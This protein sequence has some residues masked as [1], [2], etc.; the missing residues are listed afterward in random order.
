MSENKTI[1][2]FSMEVA[3][4]PEIPNFAGG[5]GVL[6]ADILKSAAD[7]GVPMVGVSLIYHQH[8]DP[9]NAFHPSKYCEK[10]PQTIFVQ[11]EGRDVK[12]GCW[13]YLIEGHGGHHVPVF[14]LDSYFPENKPWDRDLTKNLYDI[15]QYTRVCQEVILGIGGVRMLRELG[16]GDISVFHM[17]EGHASLLTLERLW[18]ERGNIDAVRKSCVFTTHTPIPAG[19]DRFPQS[20]VRQVLKEMV[21]DRFNELTSHDELHT[22]RLALRMS[23]AANGVSKKHAEVCRG[24][25]PDYEF[26][27]VTNGVHHLTWVAP[28]MQKL[29]DKQLKGWRED[30]GLMAG[31]LKLAD[32]DIRKAHTESKKKLVKYLNDHPGYL[33][34]DE[35]EI[36]KDDY[37]DEKTLT[38]TFS[39]RF[40]PYK[41]PLMLFQMVDN[42]RKIGYHKLQVIYSGVCAVYDD[43]C[44]MVMRELKH[45]QLELRGQVR[46]AVFPQRNLDSTALMAAGSDIWLNNPEPPMEACGTSGMKAAMNGCLN[47]SSP[48][49]WWIEAMQLD[50]KAGWEFGCEISGHDVFDYEAIYNGLKEVITMYYKQP[51][52]WTDRMKHAIALGAVFNSHRCVQEYQEKMWHN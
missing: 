42:L 37:F 16:V 13:K 28:P 11:I 29:F 35:H 41:R 45:L 40:V 12:I 18:E 22:T 48:D 4:H 52:E 38:I 8:D 23:R 44:N 33:I 21:P 5:L 7:L 9:K 36:E 17:N 31:A 6:A 19:H 43:Y 24:M 51:D 20:L 34:W 10:M 32:A 30:P 25:F 26:K 50:P 49:G 3:L 47:F 46:L 14:F 2:Y 39:R 1:A 15:N 27:A